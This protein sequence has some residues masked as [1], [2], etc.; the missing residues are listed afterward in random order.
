VPN[1]RPQLARAAQVDPTGQQFALVSAPMRSGTEAQALLRRLREEAAR[2]KH[3]VAVETSAHQSAQ[4]WRVSWWPFAN[5]RQAD[6]ARAALADRQ[7]EME[8]VEF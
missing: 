5:R 8:V 4:G 7:L 2:V 6:N 3:P 1:L